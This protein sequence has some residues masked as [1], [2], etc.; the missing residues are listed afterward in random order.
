MLVSDAITQVRATA[1]DTSA[2]Q[3]TD[4]QIVAWIN[5]GIRECA[6]DNNLLQKRGTQNTVVG[7]GNYV[8]PTDMLKLHT[9]RYDNK[10]LDFIT[11]EE[12]DKIYSG[13]GSDTTSRGTPNIAYIWAGVLYVYPIPDAVKVLT[14][15]YSKDAAQH[16]TGAVG[17]ELNLPVSYHMRIIDYCLAQI[18]QQ[19]ED[20]NRY[21]TKMQEFR[22]GVQ[23][24]K[25]QDE[26]AND[27]YPSISV[28]E[29]DMGDGRV[30]YLW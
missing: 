17:V 3:F 1:G 26:Y 23:M 25:D 16:T 27:L 10:K 19:D 24:V 7:Q 11:L 8:I 29:R 12:F 2:L 18:A 9:V 5:N 30:D 21:A 15:D 13:V 14:V 6:T 4:A 22:T 28:S 20:L